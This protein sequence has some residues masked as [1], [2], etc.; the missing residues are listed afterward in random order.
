[1]TLDKPANVDIFTEFRNEFKK[2]VGFRYMMEPQSDRITEKEIL[3]KIAN[4][5]RVP[6]KD[7]EKDTIKFYGNM[8]IAIIYPP[9][10]LNL[11]TFMIQINHYNKQSS[12]GAG[13]SLFISIQTDIANQQSYIPAAFVT[14]NPRGYKFRKEMQ[15]RLHST[16]I[17]QLLQKEE[18]KV[19]LQGDRLFAGWTVPIPLLP[20]K[21]VLSPSCLTI[22][23]YGKIKTYVS[24]V[25][26]YMNRCVSYEFSS[27]DAFVTFMYPSSK[28]NG[29]GSDAVLHRD[30]I[31]TSRPPSAWKE[32]DI[33]AQ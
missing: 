3:D 7:P 28:Y 19:H 11:P 13:S 4:A 26:G 2:I 5:V 29:P 17:V 21:Y 1:M 25:K 23:G 24:D 10:E 22:E 33:S 20:P 15:A 31:T 8:G 9:K 18:L 6:A 16:E 14:D 32:T 12:F 30:I 27:L